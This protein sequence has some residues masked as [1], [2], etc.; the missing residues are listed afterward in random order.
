M[1]K[2]LVNLCLLK[3]RKAKP[4][5]SQTKESIFKVKAELHENPYE[6]WIVTE[7]AALILKNFNVDYKDLKIKEIIKVD[8]IERR[9]LWLTDFLI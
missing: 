8:K 2:Q 6:F 1:N 9:I 7:S 3:F 5:A 4:K